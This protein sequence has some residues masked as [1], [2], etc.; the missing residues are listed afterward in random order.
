MN[1]TERQ[2]VLEGRSARMIGNPV[3]LGP[4][5]DG[6]RG[7]AITAAAKGNRAGVAATPFCLIRNLQH[8]SGAS[9]EA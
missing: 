8:A 9:E 3:C 2:Q 5:A 1:P 6:T 4:P 7:H